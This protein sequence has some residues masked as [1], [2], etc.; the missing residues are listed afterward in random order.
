[1][2]GKLVLRDVSEADL[3]VFFAHQTDPDASRMAAFPPREWEA[4]L[5]HW[6]RILADETVLKKTILLDGQA[7]GNV[8]SFL[9][10]GDREV[11]YWVG[12]EFWGKGIATQALAAFLFLEKTRPLYAHVA[13]HNLA[14]QR[15][16]EKCAFEVIGED[17]WTPTA[18][19]EVVEE[20]IL[21]LR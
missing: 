14:S 11:G 2:P 13:K 6:T 3:P 19:G 20:Y 12:K 8:V 9:Q 15:V 21:I 7:V 10:S 1:M 18:G 17:S 5:A 4:F 16:L